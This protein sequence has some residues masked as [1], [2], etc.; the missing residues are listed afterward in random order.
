[1]NGRLLPGGE[2]PPPQGIEEIAGQA[3]RIPERD[4]DLPLLPRRSVMNHCLSVPDLSVRGKPEKARLKIKTESGQGHVRIHLAR[5]PQT[6]VLDNPHGI[7]P[8]QHG[9]IETV[10]PAACGQLAVRIA[11]SVLP[12]EDGHPLV[13]FPGN[14]CGAG[15]LPLR[16]PGEVRENIEANR[17]KQREKQCNNP[18][19]DPM[20]LEPDVLQRPLPPVK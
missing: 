10:A 6:D 2:C 20:P 16:L 11:D 8:H 13:L 3:R 4:L 5:R 18:S 17:Q 19:C 12:L 15:R 9:F 7:D 1:M 14:G